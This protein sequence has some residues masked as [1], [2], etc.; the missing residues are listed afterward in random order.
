MSKDSIKRKVVEAIDA[1]ADEIIEIG[2]AIWRK[3]ELGFKEF[4]TAELTERKYGEMGWA[5]E[6]KIGITGSKAYLKKGGRGPVVGIIG[7]LDAIRV[8]DHP[9][10]DPITGAAHSC[11]HNAQMA[12]MLGAGFGLNDVMGELDGNVA[13]LTVPAEEYLEIDYRNSLREK[14]KLEFF[15][16]KQ[17]FIRLGYMKDIDISIGSHTDSEIKEKLSVG[18]SNNGFVGKMV[19]YIGQEAHAG[20]SPHKGINALNAAML[21]LMAIHAQRETFKDEDT[22]RVHPIITKGGEIVNNVPADVRMESYVRGKTV[23]AIKDANAKVNRAL[24]AGAMAVGAEVEI[25]N[26][27]G[28]MP[29]IKDAG[30]DAVLKANAAALVGEEQIKVKGHSTGSTDLGDFSCIMPTTSIGMGG[31]TG[32]GHS[33]H[34]KIVDKE[35]AYVLPAKVMALTCVDLLYD[36]AKLAK[37]ITKGFKPAIPPGGYEGFMKS[38]VA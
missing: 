28:Y 11:G 18:G 20:G 34:F 16:G 33:R 4:H 3:P 31:C 7:E 19:H 37:E 6:S 38:L 8:P 30:L 13:L 24:K 1:R 2:E 23:E 32:A 26:H 25:D 22:I 29:Y 15:G 36:K 10:C 21:G 5:Y 14:G 9:D 12:A 35:T 27:P 17:E